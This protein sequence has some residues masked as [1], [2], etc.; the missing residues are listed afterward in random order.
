MQVSIVRTDTNGAYAWLSMSVLIATKRGTRLQEVRPPATT[1]AS[2]GDRVA[3]AAPKNLSGLRGIS[4]PFR[5]TGA[6]CHATLAP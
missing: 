6:R 3:G 2:K 4:L 1:G 5:R